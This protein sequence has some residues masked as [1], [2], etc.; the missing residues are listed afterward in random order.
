MAYHTDLY[1]YTFLN[2]L[3]PFSNLIK[4]G[5]TLILF[6]IFLFSANYTIYKSNSQLFY[7]L[8]R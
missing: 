8:L 4:D 1:S 7:T 6:D 3:F 2:K 5:I